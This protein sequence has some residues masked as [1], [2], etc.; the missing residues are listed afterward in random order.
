[1]TTQYSLLRLK[2]FPGVAVGI[3]F[4]GWTWKSFGAAFGLGFGLISPIIGLVFTAIAWLTG[5][6]WHK[7]SV[8]RY[9]TVLFFL[10]L[11]L[12]IFGAHCLDL[13]DKDEQKA[14][15]ARQSTTKDGG[16]QLRKEQSDN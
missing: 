15:L 7:F 2:V 5:P 3:R 1:M 12:L 10:T 6:E 11:P 16:A 9:G 8:H 13:I 4:R 14:K